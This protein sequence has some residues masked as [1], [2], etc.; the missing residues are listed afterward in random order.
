MKAWHEP[1]NIYCAWLDTSNFHFEAFGTTSAE[2]RCTLIE[3]LEAHARDYQLERDWWK[4][5]EGDICSKAITLGKGYRDNESLTLEF[6]GSN[7]E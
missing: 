6:E 7:V 1:I 2:T 4:R 5:W 3:T